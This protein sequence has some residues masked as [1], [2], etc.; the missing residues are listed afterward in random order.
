MSTDAQFPKGLSSPDPDTTEPFDGPVASFA[1][2]RRLTGTSPNQVPDMLSAGPEF[3]PH[4]KTLQ[5]F[6]LGR[7]PIEGYG[8]TR[9]TDAG[10][11]LYHDLE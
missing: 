3:I 11:A 6:S 1:A 2:L 4:Q 7:N 5:G 10:I 9:H 8:P